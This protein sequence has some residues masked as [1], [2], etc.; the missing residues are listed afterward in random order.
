MSRHRTLIFAAATM[1]ATLWAL[2]C[3]DG[4]TEPPP[5]PPRPTTVTVS[6]ATAELTA[7]G[8]TVQLRAQVLDQYGQVMAGAA[9]SW[10]SSTASVAPV[11]ASGLVTAAANGTATITATAG[12][13]SGTATVT[14]A[15]VVSTVEVSPAA[16]TVVERDTVRF[17]AEARDANG[18]AVAGAAFTWASGDRSVAVVDASGLVT[19]TGEGEVEVAATSSGVTGRAEL[20]VEALVPT[21]VSVAPSTLAFTA[22]GDTVRLMAEVR[23]QIDR[24]MEGEPVAWTSAEMMVAAVDSTGL[25]TAVANGAAT[26]TAMAGS[27]SGTA[28]VTVAQRTSTVAVSPA[29]ATVVERDT[30]RFEAEARDA[31]GHAVAGAAF[32]WASG[33]RSVAVVDA[34]GLVTGTGEGEVEVAAT[35][36]GV[37]GR[38]ELVV[39]A[40]VPTTVSVAPST[41]AF[42]AL[43][44]TVR[45]MAEVRDQ[46]DRVMEGEPVAWTS[47]EMMVAA[48]DS[49]GLVTAVANGAATITAMAGS[50]SGTAAV[51]VRS[52]QAR[53]KSRPRPPRWWSVTRYGSRRRPGTRT[54]MRWRR[55][56]S[57][58]PPATHR[59]RWWTRRG[60]SPGRARAR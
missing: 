46:I 28:A 50:A 59:W 20:V 5:D 43:G 39:E 32:T 47:A 42:T 56:R 6:P 45:L 57:R 36:S 4:A 11:D 19:G 15:Q 21:T 7:L 13:A 52:G 3:G 22:L 18:H 53:S 27:A 51:T 10:S 37:T 12:S 34:S 24:V 16:D 54:A 29:A 17:E 49:T 44:D 48:V 2:S 9:V 40:L 38:A 26:I 23:D 60:W 31:N 14:V 30:V 58:G 25:V 55:P 41:L 1:S 35:S 33:D 8:A